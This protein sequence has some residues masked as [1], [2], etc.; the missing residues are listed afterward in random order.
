M[1]DDI[2]SVFDDAGARVFLHAR[3]LDGDEDFGI[4]AD[5]P[6]IINYNLEFKTDDPFNLA[7]PFGASDH[8]PL[9][10]GLSPSA[11]VDQTSSP[12]MRTR[13]ANASHISA[14]TVK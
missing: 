3:A 12:A 4:D 2:T 14:T 7:D 13:N 8:D 6:V 10:V 9:I 11:A 1:R 5:E